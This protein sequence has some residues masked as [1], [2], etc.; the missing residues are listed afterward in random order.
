MSSFSR[1]VDSRYIA[2]AQLVTDT[3]TLTAG[4]I[5]PTV[6]YTAVT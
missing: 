5:V 3:V 1:L 6:A 4:R 2:Y